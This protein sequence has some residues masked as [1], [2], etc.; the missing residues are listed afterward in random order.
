MKNVNQSRSIGL[1]IDFGL[2]LLRV[3][4]GLSLCF[5]FGLPKLRAAV[6]YFHTGQWQFIDFN[7]KFGLPAPVLVAY[8]QSLNESVAALLVAIGLFTRYSAGLLFLGFAVATYCSLKAGEPA[9]L[10]AGYFGLM[11]ATIVFTGP[12]KFSVDVLLRSRATA[13]TSDA[14]KL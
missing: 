8:V 9:W 6:A 14:S 11:F 5:F 2:L 12:G 13:N 10:M 1:G 3:G 7:R 4:V